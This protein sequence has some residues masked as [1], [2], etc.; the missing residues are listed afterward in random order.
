MVQ[1]V[2]VHLDLRKVHVN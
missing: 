2:N 1:G